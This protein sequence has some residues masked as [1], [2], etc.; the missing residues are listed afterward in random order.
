[1]VNIAIAVVLV[2]LFIA[3]QLKQRPAKEQSG[4]R[5]MLILGVIG[6]VDTSNAFKGHHVDALTVALIVAGV[7][8]GLA[9][10]LA[11]AVTTR[12]WRDDAGLAWRQGT[13]LTAGLWIVSLATHLGLD[14]IVDY[15]SGVSG[16]GT[17]TLLLYLA[18]TLGAQQEIVRLRAAALRPVSV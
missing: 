7:L 8:M 14:A 18:V 4:L 16:L 5:L 10:G 2:G 17:S 12:V 6:I 1:M 11:R 9:F 15:Q 13:W 3:R